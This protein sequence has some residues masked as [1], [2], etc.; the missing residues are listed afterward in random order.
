MM[1]SR[2]QDWTQSTS[3][4]SNFGSKSCF[5]KLA[6]TGSHIYLGLKAKLVIKVLKSV[7]PRL[8][9]EWGTQPPKIDV[10][11]STSNGNG[12]GNSLL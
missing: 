2:I 9:H 5:L 12:N 3:Y 7:I 11:P 6:S 4:L 1:I 10:K 8:V